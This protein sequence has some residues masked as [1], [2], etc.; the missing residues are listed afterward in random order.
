MACGS[1]PGL[2][3]VGGRA[4]EGMRTSFFGV[5][6][7]YRAGAYRRADARYAAIIARARHGSDSGLTTELRGGRFTA[8]K[9]PCRAPAG[10]SAMG[11]LRTTR[12]LARRNRPKTT[13]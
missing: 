2:A 11:Q 5:L 4:E 9:P 12:F 3:S 6:S 13:L 10:I 1:R 7:G 8:S